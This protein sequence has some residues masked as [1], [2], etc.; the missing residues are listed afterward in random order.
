[1][2]QTTLAPYL[3]TFNQASD[4]LLKCFFLFLHSY[5]LLLGADAIIHVIRHVASQSLRLRL[6]FVEFGIGFV[7]VL[8]DLLFLLLQVSLF[9]LNVL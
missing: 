8:I 6:M 2:L 1:M 4:I 3:H 5:F 7:N 9:E